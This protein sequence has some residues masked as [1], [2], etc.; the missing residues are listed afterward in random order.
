[1]NDDPSVKKVEVINLGVPGYN[2]S[3]Y[4]KSLKIEGFR[5]DPDLVIMFFYVGNDWSV[6]EG[7][8]YKGVN[9]QGFLINTKD[10]FSMKSARSAL[11]YIRLFLKSHSQAYMLA[12]DRFKGF[13]MKAK[14]M[15]ISTVDIYEKSNDLRKKY[16]YTLQAINEINLF[17]K[18]QLSCPFLV[19]IVPEKM[20]VKKSLL[21]LVIRAYK[22]NANEYNWLQPQSVLIEFCE[23]NGI[24]YLDLTG[25]LGEA[26]QKEPMYL[27]VDYHW[28]RMGHLIAAQSIYKYLK[29]NQIIRS[30]KYD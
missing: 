7:N 22:L 2:S 25:P 18:T 3:Q 10:G 4:E 29:D 15:A 26:E 19:C 12:R 21:N 17:C 24:N 1:M 20:Q 8:D 9:S 14:L 30:R 5:Y 16:A 13:L 11:F 6:D 27:D 28:N 23:E